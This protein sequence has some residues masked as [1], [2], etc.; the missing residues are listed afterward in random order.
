[1]NISFNTGVNSTNATNA[2]S[3]TGQMN[4]IPPP[5]AKLAEDLSISTAETVPGD[6]PDIDFPEDER[7]ARTDRLGQLVSAAFSLP[8]P[9]PDF[10]NRL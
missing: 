9:P 10:M 7:N 2:A 1:M 3:Q 6:V 5:K 8:A 4:G